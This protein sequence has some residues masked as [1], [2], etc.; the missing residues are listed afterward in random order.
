MRAEAHSSYHATYWFGVISTILKRPDGS[1]SAT[2][3]LGRTW[4]CIAPVE[5][6]CSCRVSEYRYLA[7]GVAKKRQKLLSHGVGG[8]VVPA[9]V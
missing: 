2:C 8:D 9:Q 1:R 6:V 5:V 4:E 3:V 7:M